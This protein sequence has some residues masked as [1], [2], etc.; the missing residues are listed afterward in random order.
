MSEWLG[1]RTS[2]D[3]ADDNRLKGEKKKEAISVRRDQ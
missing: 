1:D 3:K 2:K